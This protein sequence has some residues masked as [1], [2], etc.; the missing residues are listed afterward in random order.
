MPA[1]HLRDAF[2]GQSVALTS[3]LVGKSTPARFAVDF[4]E[5]AQQDEGIDQALADQYK[6]DGLA[7]LQRQWDRL[8]DSPDSIVFVSLQLHDGL[9]PIVA[10]VI[11]QVAIFVHK[12]SGM[13]RPKPDNRIHEK[14]GSSRRRSRP[15]HPHFML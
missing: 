15:G 2:Y 9:S 3:L 4:I 13:N 1:P 8:M 12:R 11:N 10:G 6:I 14:S 5:Q 7:G